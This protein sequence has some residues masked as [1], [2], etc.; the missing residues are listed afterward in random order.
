M[1]QQQS[2]YIAPFLSAY[3]HKCYKRR[4]DSEQRAAH[5]QEHPLFT[6]LVDAKRLKQRQKENRCDGYNAQFID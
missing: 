4:Q 5:Y 1:K 2:P 3:Q 6:H